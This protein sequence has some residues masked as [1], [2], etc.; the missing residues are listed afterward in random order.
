MLDIKC[1]VVGPL[2]VNC[3]VLTDCNE[4]AVID[5]GGDCDRIIDMIG[6]SHLKM[7]LL[8]HGHYDHTGAVK[9][10]AVKTGAKIFIHKDDAIMLED[11]TKNLSSLSNTEIETVSAD[12][13]LEN[14]QSIKLGESEI[15][16]Y[17]TPGHSDGSVSLYCSGNLFDGDLL[18]KGTIGRFD[19]G[20]L[21]TEFNSLRFLMDNFDDEVKVFPGHGEITS[22]GTE[23]NQNPYLLRHLN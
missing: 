23:R 20:N 15:K 16:V 8:T 14:G 22:I 10:L 18:F 17:H 5:P 6:N 4:S 1:I 12:G 3:Y 2:D 13:F 21:R 9:E 11:N 7:I 19:H